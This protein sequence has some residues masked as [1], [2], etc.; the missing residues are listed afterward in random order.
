[1]RVGVLVL[2]QVLLRRSCTRGAGMPG[3]SQMELARPKFRCDP[4]P[5][6]A[7]ASI[8]SVCT[9]VHTVSA[10]IVY[11][12]ELLALYLSYWKE[13]IHRRHTER[14][15]SYDTGASTV[16]TCILLMPECKKT[17]SG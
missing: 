4:L 2:P 12:Y 8:N 5:P 6:P 7:V 13:S 15:I 9:H 1:M 16:C 10:N 17:D 3:A 11:S 14:Y